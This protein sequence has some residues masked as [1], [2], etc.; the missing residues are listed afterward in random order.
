MPGA[1]SVNLMTIHVVPLRFWY[2]A[3]E[4]LLSRKAAQ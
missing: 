4:A 1:D 2:L 3:L